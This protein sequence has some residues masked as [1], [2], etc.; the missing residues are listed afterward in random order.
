LTLLLACMNIANLLLARA[1]ARTREL[2]VRRALGAGRERIIRQ[3]LTESAFLGLLGCVLGVA[4]AY[5]SVSALP[6]L[7][8]PD[9]PGMREVRIDLPVLGFAVLLSLLASMG[10]G[11]APALLTTGSNLQGSLRDSAARSGSSA[12]PLRIRRFLAAAEIGLAVIQVIC[13]GLLVRSLMSITSVNPGFRVQQISKAEISLPRYRYSTPQQW[14]TFSRS[15]LERVQWTPGLQDSAIV[16]PLPL[17]DGFINLGFSIPDHAALPPGTPK[18]ADY[19]SVTP[20]Y[21]HVLGVP[22]LRGRSFDE[23]DSD[24]APVVTIISESFALL[25]FRGEDPIGKKLKFGFP[26]NGDA[27]RT[28]VGVVG[29]IRDASLTAQPGPMMYVPFF[30]APFWGGDLVV[31]SSQSA[32]AVA[33]SIRRVVQSLDPDLPVTVT[34]MPDVVA[35]QVA[36][37]KIRTVLVGL[38]GLVSLLLAALGVFGLLSY[39]VA[40][41]IRE[42][43]V[44]AALG[45]TPALIG[46]MILVEGT[47]V[48]AGGLVLG[49]A[50]AAGLVRFLE[51]ELYGVA[52]YDPTT[53]LGST[54]ILLL[55]AALACYLP[56]RRAMRLDPVIAL[57]TE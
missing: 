33:R 42:F 51:S 25:Y 8:P 43:G 29:D 53:F 57:R 28:I 49:L 50:A 23:R 39:S 40:S 24:G 44:R 38:F 3:L 14:R 11:L 41:R 48:G 17:G 46:K 2:A 12:G 21:F 54:A 52:A 18:T 19:V 56:A 6:L 13:A 7:F 30:Q 15:L 55:F 32:V 4:L 1:T 36:Q 9:L 5:A 10:F 22:L 27:E 26:P 34:T 31:N 35:A 20:S 37:P 16:V 45:A 47:A